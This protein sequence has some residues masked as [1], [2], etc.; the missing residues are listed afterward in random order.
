MISIWASLTF[1]SYITQWV[2]RMDYLSSDFL[3]ASMSPFLNKKALIFLKCKLLQENLYYKIVVLMWIMYRPSLKME[4]PS[5]ASCSRGLSLCGSSRNCK[6]EV[7]QLNMKRRL[8][9]NTWCWYLCITSVSVLH[10]HWDFAFVRT[11]SCAIH[12]KPWASLTLLLGHFFSSQ[13]FW[14]W[15]RDPAPLTVLS[16]CSVL[17]CLSL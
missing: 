14:R 5:T 10:D 6:E 4:K 1:P 3:E 8:F 7:Q 2:S 13:G 15:K 9:E 12:R 17:R 11:L 16:L